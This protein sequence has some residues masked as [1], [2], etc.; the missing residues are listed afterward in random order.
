MR[1]THRVSE[2]GIVA[3]AETDGEVGTIIVSASM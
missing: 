2:V 1:D 3:D